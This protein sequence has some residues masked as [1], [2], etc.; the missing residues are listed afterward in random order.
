MTAAT[1][2]QFVPDVK[3]VVFACDDNVSQRICQEEFHIGGDAYPDKTFAF[4]D[5][6]ERLTSALIDLARAESGSFVDDACAADDLVWNAFVRMYQLWV[7]FAS[8]MVTDMVVLV[9]VDPMCDEFM[10]RLL[11]EHSDEMVMCFG[12]KM[13]TFKAPGERLSTW[14]TWEKQME[15]ATMFSK[16]F[17]MPMLFHFATDV[18]FDG[19]QAKVLSVWDEL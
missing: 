8:D 19:L 9:K 11:M 10:L 13:H 14:E 7:R 12:M 17:K 5:A 1:K 18:D 2:R 15:N 16:D 6:S 4:F 3:L